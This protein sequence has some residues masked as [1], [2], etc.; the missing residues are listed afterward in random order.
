MNLSESRTVKC[1]YV[2][3]KYG[4]GGRHHLPDREKCVHSRESADRW[5]GIL[6]KAKGVH[7]IKVEEG[8]TEICSLIL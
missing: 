4:K 1:W 2:R 3:Y 6:S 5:V 7:N 8:T